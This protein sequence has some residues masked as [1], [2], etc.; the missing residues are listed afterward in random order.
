[1]HKAGRAEMQRLMQAPLAE[2]YFC[3]DDVLAIGAL[4]AAQGAGLRVPQDIGLIGLNDMKMAAWANIALTTIHQ[5]FEAIVQSSADLILSSFA[6]PGSPP[7][8]RLF[9]CHIVERSTL[10]PLG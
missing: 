5:P 2:A 4:S 9:P 3:G 10:R 1:M 7:E 8:V 6:E